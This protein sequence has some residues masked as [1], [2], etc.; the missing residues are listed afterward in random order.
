LPNP[1][2]DVLSVL[3]GRA[4]AAPLR[5]RVWGADG[6]LV[7]EGVL[8]AGA[9]RLVLAVGDLPRGMYFVQADAAVRKVV[10]R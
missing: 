8:R 10:L 2:S 6:R 3:L 4:A 5:V 9:E 7:L 1:A